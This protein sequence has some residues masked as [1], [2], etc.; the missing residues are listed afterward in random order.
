MSDGPHSSLDMRRGWKRLAE[1]AA[2]KAFAPEEVCDALPKALEQD[3][4][5]EVAE[6][7]HRQIGTILGDRQNSL[8]G[9]QRMEQLEAL[10]SSTAG[11]PLGGVFLDCAIQAAARGR[12]GDRAF[13]EAAYGALLDRAT[14][15]ARQVEEHYR[16]KST[17]NRAT[18]VRERI[19]SG[20]T[21]TDFTA[22]AGYLVG[23]DKAAQ[24][25]MPA[26]KT[27]LDDGVQI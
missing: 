1:S 16:R 2:N 14:R 6:S 9:D 13:V 3:W 17:T 19:D 7:L 10:R 5:A 23:T 20:I 26:K 15:G 8:F 27:S 22:L 21:Q 25:R 18:H 12:T 4:R 11:F 24:P